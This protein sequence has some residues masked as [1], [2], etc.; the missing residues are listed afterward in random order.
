MTRHLQ[1]PAD[2]DEKEK[3]GKQKRTLETREGRVLFLEDIEKAHF[4]IEVQ[5]SATT[6]RKEVT[7]ERII[8]NE[9]FNSIL[10]WGEKKDLMSNE[11][12]AWIVTLPFIRHTDVDKNGPLEKAVVGLK[13]YD[14][15][16][17]SRQNSKAM[18]DEQLT[19]LMSDSF[20]EARE[21]NKM[22]QT[23]EDEDKSAEA[24]RDAQ[25]MQIRS[26]CQRQGI[27][28]ELGETLHDWYVREKG[29]DGS[30]Q[31]S[32]FFKAL[33]RAS[34]TDKSTTVSS[35]AEFARWMCSKFPQIEDMAAYDARRF[36][37]NVEAEDRATSKRSAMA[38][39]KTN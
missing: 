10:E 13:G 33:C 20:A 29:P 23:L 15:T 21:R 38:K 27:D 1:Y 36:K 30:F 4:I 26:A 3:P 32:Y 39:F 34:K 25:K 31:D 5:F 22:W 8:E 11:Q 28:I 37:E 19:K 12:Y 2:K 6:R 35:F 18:K 9:E 17:T 24:S 7:F 14:Q 16:I